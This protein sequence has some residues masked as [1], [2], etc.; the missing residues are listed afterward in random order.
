MSY[1]ETVSGRERLIVSA[2]CYQLANYVVAL[3]T[4]VFLAS[5]S[6]G[7]YYFFAFCSL[8]CTVMCAVFMFETKGHSLEFIEQKYSE[9]QQS[10]VGAGG[11]WCSGTTAGTLLRNMRSDFAHA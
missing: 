3:S 4:P 8:F 1:T 2:P 11:V 9:R 7:A 10:R 5:S 6:Y